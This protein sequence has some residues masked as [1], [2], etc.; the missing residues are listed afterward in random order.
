MRRLVATLA[1]GAGVALAMSAS[2]TVRY[3]NVNNASPAPPYTNWAF[4]AAN[5]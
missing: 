5:I 1:A 2:A 4:A 3:V